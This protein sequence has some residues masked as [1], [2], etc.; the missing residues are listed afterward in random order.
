MSD[1]PDSIALPSVIGED[2]ARMEDALAEQ[3]TEAAAGRI[4]VQEALDA[5]EAAVNALLG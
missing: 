1:A 5:A 4:S 3:L 2:Q